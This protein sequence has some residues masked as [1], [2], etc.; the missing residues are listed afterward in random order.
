MQRTFEGIANLRRCFWTF[1][2]SQ[3]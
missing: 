1:K 3:S 2:P